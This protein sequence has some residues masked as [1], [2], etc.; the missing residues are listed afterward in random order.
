M[1]TPHPSSAQAH[2]EVTP[3]ESTILGL[4]LAWDLGYT[5][6]IPAILGC[7]GGAWLDKRYG[8]GNAFFF[9]GLLTSFFFSCLGIYKKIRLILKR[10]PKDL[11]RKERPLTSGIDHS[12][13]KEQDELHALFRPPHP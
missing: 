3:N 11:P 4:S 9:V 2:K 6:A 12:V 13:Q 1:H 7:V 5:I 10:M 8:T